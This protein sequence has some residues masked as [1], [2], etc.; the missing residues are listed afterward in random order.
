[1]IAQ[2][3]KRL[4]KVSL[5][6]SLILTLNLAG[7]SGYAFGTKVLPTDTDIGRPLSD[8]PAR[9]TLCYWDTGTPGYDESDVAYLHIA[10]LDCNTACASVCANDVRLTPFI[11]YPAGSRVTSRDEDIGMPLT[12]LRATINYLNL[13]GSQAYDL[14]DPVYVHQKECGYSDTRT[15][16]DIKDGF[17]ERL[18]P[19]GD[20]NPY[21]GVNCLTFTDGYKLLV[22]DQ[23]ADSIPEAV[24]SWRGLSVELVHGIKND[25]YHVLNTWLVK[26]V[27]VDM[28]ANGSS[29]IYTIYANPLICTNDIRLSFVEELTAGTKVIDFDV[30]QN[31]FVSL[32]PLVSFPAQAADKAKIRY[33]D[34]NG[35][36]V[37]DYQDDVYLDI[38][39]ESSGNSVLVNDVRLSGPV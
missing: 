16:A 29:D 33:F 1:L 22:S 39:K 7:G 13:H 25:Y 11:E 15:A 27:K 38:P 17:G 26:I 35:N 3:A 4:I 10:P 5:L 18:P 9:T 32:P 12:P 2:G 34:A 36:G 14:E 21:I 24:G 28:S 37:Y 23:L 20:R 19:L 6:M 31:K 8:M 30:D